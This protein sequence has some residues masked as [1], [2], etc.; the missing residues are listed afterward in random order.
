MAL[1]SSSDAQTLRDVL[2]E[3]TR[4]VRVRFF[5][6]TFGCDTCLQA[7]QIL[8]ELPA[9]SDTIT[10]EELNLVL[11]QDAAKEYGIDRAPAIVLT[12]EDPEAPGTWKDSRM[13]FLG[14]PAGHEFVSLVQAVL[15]AGGR[16]STLTDANRAK[17]AAVD[18]PL[19]VRVFSTPSCPHCPRAI[20]LAHEMAFA[21]PLI[22]A[23]AIE[24][25]SFPDL[26]RQYQVTG[27]PKTI[28]ND[29]VEILGALPQDDFIQQ[30][31]AVADGVA[32]S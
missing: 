2:Q 10:I 14:A 11:D 19:T 5:T 24:A 27:V 18:K 29:D 16:P 6:Q 25:T 23:I 26:T 13:R 7:R 17:L 12:Y 30:A 31:L 32:R 1:L 28:V 22:T 9:L 21:N 20:T 15:L 4:P 8:D 3:L